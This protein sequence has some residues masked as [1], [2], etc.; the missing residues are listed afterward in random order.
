MNTES[1]LS[2]IFQLITQTAKANYT[3]TSNKSVWKALRLSHPAWPPHAPHFHGDLVALQV[4]SL[5]MLNSKE[6]Q[7]WLH[8]IIFRPVKIYSNN[9]DTDTS[10]RYMFQKEYYWSTHLWQHSKD[11][12]HISAVPGRVWQT[13]QQAVR[14]LSLSANQPA[15]LRNAPKK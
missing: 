3:S 14:T 2:F 8:I 15:S 11:L 13:D 5:S 1:P 12:R 7:H 10:L 4:C 9:K 6:N